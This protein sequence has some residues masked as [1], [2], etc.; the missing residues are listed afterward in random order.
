MYNRVQL[1]NQSVDNLYFSICQTSLGQS[2]TNTAVSADKY[3]V[4]IKPNRSYS[5]MSQSSVPIK[6]SLFPPVFYDG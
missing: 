3:F 5:S 1:N 4:Y 6:C 2:Q